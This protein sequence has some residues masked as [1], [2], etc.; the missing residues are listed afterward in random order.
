MVLK[1][2]E[3][4]TRMLVGTGVALAAPIIES[5]SA[6]AS[7]LETDEFDAGLA[8][9]SRRLYNI[10]RDHMKFQSDPD[11]LFAQAAAAWRDAFAFRKLAP[12]RAI[13]RA[14]DAEA[15]AAGL[16]A[17]FYGDRGNLQQAQSWYAKAYEVAQE[18]HVKAWLVGCQTWIPLYEGN[19]EVAVKV[20]Q[21]ARHFQTFRDPERL[22][23]TQMQAARAHALNGDLT[24]A[25]RAFYE[26][27]SQFEKRECDVHRK[28]EPNLLFFTQWQFYQYAAEIMG[29]VGK[30]R[31]ARSYHEEALQSPHLNG[32]NKA[33]LELGESRIRLMEG[34]AGGAAQHAIDTLLS[35]KLSDATSA[36]VK[37][38]VV[39]LADELSQNYGNIA[40]VREFNDFKNE[41]VAAA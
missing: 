4:L 20:A 24:Q 9:V 15:F 18:R 5:A 23:F 2:R 37:G 38:R 39:A 41:L 28:A 27:E 35:L 3:L 16:I 17:Q 19:G 10:G 31:Q 11:V 6:I 29:S 36:V 8:Q 30:F 1:R 14:T 32:M 12:N 34:D 26:A 7:P 40:P 21:N 33:V 22:V 13:R 25:R